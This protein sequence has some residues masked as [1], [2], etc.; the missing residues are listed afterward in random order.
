MRSLPKFLY[1]GLLS[2]LTI[3]PTLTFAESLPL[4]SMPIPQTTDGVRMYRLASTRSQSLPKRSWIM[5]P[6]FRGSTLA[7]HAS[8]CRAASGFNSTM[9]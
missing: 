9:I 2:V 1:S 5:S 7:Q 8:H 3:S 6:V 4:R